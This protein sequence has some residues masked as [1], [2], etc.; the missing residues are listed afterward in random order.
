M[1][2][3][4]H[5]ENV[6]PQ[7]GPTVLNVDGTQDC[8]KLLV[9]AYTFQSNQNSYMNCGPFLKTGFWK[10]YVA[11]MGVLRTCGA[12]NPILCQEP[13]ALEVSTLLPTR[14]KRRPCGHK[15]LHTA[16]VQYHAK[17]FGEERV[18]RKIQQCVCMVC[19]RIYEYK[20]I[21]IHAHLHTHISY[22]Y[23][24]TNVNTCILIYV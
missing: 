23:I 17:L 12:Q 11:H 1:L 18:K 20:H 10:V 24:Y 15:L 4:A 3:V 6:H 22:I 21:H 19:V 16:V 5:R 2:R 13:Q 8:H 14:H 7:S 9:K